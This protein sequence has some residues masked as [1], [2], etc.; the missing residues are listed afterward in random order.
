MDVL[1]RVITYDLEKGPLIT[2]GRNSSVFLAI[3]ISWLLSM[4]EE[5]QLKMTESGTVTCVLTRK[6][7]L[8]RLQCVSQFYI[9]Q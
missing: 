3:K 5:N 7:V 1:N 9:P 8:K 4:Y 2:D 6:I